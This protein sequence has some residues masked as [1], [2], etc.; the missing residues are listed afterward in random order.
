MFYLF[1]RF[2]DK[3]PDWTGE[4]AA[5]VSSADDLSTVLQSLWV[6]PTIDELYVQ[7][8]PALLIPTFSSDNDNSNWSDARRMM[9]HRDTTSP[10]KDIC[11]S[12]SFLFCILI[13]RT[14]I[15]I[16]IS[17]SHPIRAKE[18]IMWRWWDGPS[19]LRARSLGRRPCFIRSINS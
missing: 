2:R 11:K 14:S 13:T 18:H 5:V 4:Q 17:Q 16:V 19:T 8:E 1:L 10:G 3:H 15:W 7:L 12:G 6:R 9:Q